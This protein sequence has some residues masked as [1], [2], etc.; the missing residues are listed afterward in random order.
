M[1]LTVLVLGTSTPVAAR[2]VLGLDGLMPNKVESLDVQKKRA[3]IQ[4][5][6]KSTDMEKYMFLAHLRNTNVSLF[7]KIVC[8]E[9]TV[10]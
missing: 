6:S 1:Y 9:L 5:R 4:L 7:Y 2:S 8:D 10:S 3:L